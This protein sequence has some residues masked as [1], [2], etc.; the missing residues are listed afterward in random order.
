M[1]NE[2]NKKL[3]NEKT[4]RNIYFDENIKFV[5]SENDFTSLEKIVWIITFSNVKYHEMHAQKFKIRNKIVCDINIFS[6]F[7]IFTKTCCSNEH[8]NIMLF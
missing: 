4:I 6:M 2:M 3:K 5:Q 7:E 8:R 1:K